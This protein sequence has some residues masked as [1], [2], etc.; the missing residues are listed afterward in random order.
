MQG[1]FQPYLTFGT[2]LGNPYA[3]RCFLAG[4]PIL[5]SDGSSKP[6][7][8]IRPGDEVASFD[9]HAAQGLGPQKPGKVTRTFTNVTKTIINLRGTHMT[10]GHVVLMEE[11]WMFSSESKAEIKGQQMNKFLIN[12][13]MTIATMVITPIFIFFPILSP[14]LLFWL[15]FCWWLSRGL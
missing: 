10:P 9:P 14:L 7:E 2:A 5:M 8:E 1:A 11:G 15:I 12:I 6:I 13:T 3:P 4:T